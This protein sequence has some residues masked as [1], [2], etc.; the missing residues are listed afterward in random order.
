MPTHAGQYNAV[1]HLHGAPK[2]GA[3]LCHAPLPRAIFDQFKQSKSRVKWFYELRKTDPDYPPTSCL[4]HFPFSTAGELFRCQGSIW[5]FPMPSW[6]LAIK[7]SGG[8]RTTLVEVLLD[9][10][11]WTVVINVAHFI[12]VG[13]LSGA[14]TTNTPLTLCREPLFA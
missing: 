12:S 4:A 1:P 11:A 10:T 13:A 7:Q 3:S 8:W 6:M 2:R 9:Q 14:C 5:F